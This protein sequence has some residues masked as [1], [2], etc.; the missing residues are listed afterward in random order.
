MK[1]IFLSIAVCFLSVASF[2][3]AE[4]NVVGVCTKGDISYTTPKEQKQTAGKVVTSVLGAVLDAAAGQNNST[5]NHSEY[6]DAA[7]QAI[8]GGIGDARRFRFTDTATAVGKGEVL[9]YVD[10]TISSITATR[11]VQVTKD[12]KGHRHE[13]IDYKGNVTGV[14]NIKN[15]ETNDIIKTITFNTSAWSDSWWMD[16][17]DKALGNTIGCLQNYITS[18]LNSSFP[19][20]ASIIEGSTAKKDKQKEVYIDLGNPWGVY[21]N[22]S[23]TAYKVKKVAGKEA[24]TEIGR[25]KVTEVQGDEISLCKVTRGGKE[26]KAALDNGEELVITSR[27]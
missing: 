7:R 5:E 18:Q 14:I 8:F 16:T 21:K 10:G 1:K 2:A 26:L 12:D 11:R 17:A 6:L 9:C 24:K 15:T 22:M 3:Q 25:I 19:L 20:Y 4:K 13:S 27:D 23:F